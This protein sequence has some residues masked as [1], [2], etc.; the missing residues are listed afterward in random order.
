MTSS[1]LGQRIALAR[2]QAGLTQKDLAA[3]LNIDSV[4]L[5]RYENDH[6]VPDALLLGR[7]VSSLKCDAEWLLL[8][9]E[10]VHSKPG[11]VVPRKR[12]LESFTH[13]EQEYIEKLTAVMGRSSPEDVAYLKGVLDTLAT[14]AKAKKG[15]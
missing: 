9:F 10:P 8:G 4:T 13:D 2:K 6:R 1:S 5:N 14:K 11:E 12:H 3:E 7:M 15:A